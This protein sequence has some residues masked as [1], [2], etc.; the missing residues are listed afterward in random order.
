MKNRIEEIVL[1]VTPQEK[2]YIEECA[3]K[4]FLEIDQFIMLLV[5]SND[6]PSKLSEE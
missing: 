4:L 2:E 3:K 1:K 5:L 6:M